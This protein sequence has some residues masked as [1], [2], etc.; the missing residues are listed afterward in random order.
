VKT[1]NQPRLERIFRIALVV[2]AAS[3]GLLIPPAIAQTYLYNQAN[4][5]TGN[6]PAAVIVGDFDGDSRL[7]LIVANSSDNSISVLLS[8][9][10]GGFSPK[11]DYK[12]GSA[13][14]Q[15]VSA[16]FNGDGKLDLAVVNSQDNTVSI[17]LGRGDGSFLQQVTYAT[18][19][20]PVAIAAADLNGDKRVD[21]AIANSND[22]T[23]SILLGNGDG[24]FVS[25]PATLAVDFNGDGKLDVAMDDVDANGGVSVL[26]GNGD[27]T[28]GPAVTSFVGL[29][30]L[31]VQDIAA[32][33]FNKD[34]K[35]DLAL[36]TLGTANKFSPLYVLISDGDGTSPGS[37]SSVAEAELRP[38]G[39][40]RRTPERHWVPTSLSSQ[41]QAAL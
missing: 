13:P 36:L 10:S 26:M 3:L 23:V 2:L 15:L 8:N 41:P 39:V 18:G 7:D 27:G 9:I 5:G 40:K 24:T 38:Q 14:A 17:L 16:D 34:G 29:T 33:D 35:A 37:Q 19:R 11:V 28:F 25:Q 22:G 20:Q 6:K 31:N 1:Q 30:G 21:L 12:V 32:S 4:L